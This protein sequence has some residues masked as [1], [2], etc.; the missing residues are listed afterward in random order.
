MRWT[1]FVPFGR[2]KLSLRL[3]ARRRRE[4]N[5]DLTLIFSGHEFDDRRQQHSWGYLAPVPCLRSERTATIGVTRVSV[6]TLKGAALGMRQKPQPK[7]RVVDFFCGCGG[8]SLGLR[9]AGMSIAAGID[10]DEDAGRT[11]QSIFPR[12]KFL[13][14][15]IRKL[16]PADL[17]EVVESCRGSPLLFSCCAP[18]QPFSRHR[19]TRRRDSR[20]YL[21]SGFPKFVRRYLPKYVICENVPKLRRF[22][23]SKGPFPALVRYLKRLGYS[24]ATGIVDSQDFGV[25]QR[26]R[27]LVL[28]ASFEGPI[29]I[30]APTHGPGRPEPYSG[31]WDWIRDLPKLAAGGADSLDPV[32]RAANL[33]PLNLRR[34]RATPPEG[35]RLDWPASLRLHCHKGKDRT[36]TDVYGRIRKN[37]PASAMTTRC[38]VLSSGRFGHPVQHRAI[39]AREAACLQTFP[40]TVKFQ[41]SLE[42]MARQIGNAVPVKLARALGEQI[43]QHHSKGARRHG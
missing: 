15:D 19:S 26:R 34:L 1:S 2:V 18:C 23:G 7:L 11:F 14:K 20:K 30:P 35:S 8:T 40:L 6:A 5:I 12:A 43:A 42:S 33:S 37:V 38:I 32:H 17:E 36:F 4:S 3:G 27:R 25:P 29:S 31:A 9:Q 24:C 41:G 22:F 28:L 21:L 10:W 39:S 16:R 13:K